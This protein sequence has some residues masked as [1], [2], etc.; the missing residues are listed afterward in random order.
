M[1]IILIVLFAAFS[2]KADNRGSLYAAA[3]P[4]LPLIFR[5]RL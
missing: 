4:V 3:V 2:V 1:A 5:F